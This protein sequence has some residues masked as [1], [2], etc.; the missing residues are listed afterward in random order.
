MKQLFL[1]ILGAG[2]VLLAAAQTE[3][4]LYMGTYTGTG[5]HG[6]Y[7]AKVNTA[8]GIIRLVD[9]LAAD[10]PSYLALNKAGNRLYAVTENGGSNPGAATSFMREEGTGKWMP[11]NASPQLTGGDHPCYIAVNKAGTHAVVANYTGGSVSVFAID[12]AGALGAASQLIQHRGSSVNKGRQEKPHVHST[13]FSP[14]EQYLMVADLGTDY[15]TAY[16]FHANNASAPL[17]TVKALRLKLSA[18]AGPRH[19]SFHPTLP[20]VYVMEELSG[21][22]AV[23][24]F[25]PRQRQLQVL[26]TIQSDRVSKQPGS[27][28]IHLS[29]DGKF[30]YASN[31]IEANDLAVFAVDAGTGQL[32][33]VQSI[34]TGGIKPRNFTLSPDG[35][36]VLVANQESNNIVLF[37]RHAGTGLLTPANVTLSLPSPVCLVFGQ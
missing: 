7:V 12:H 27:A 30:L 8:T 23:V 9:S 26:Q 14:N 25:A 34:R 20:I 21:K 19:V 3:W 5:S 22:V 29:P 13:I 24:R 31:R 6:I 1:S 18:G 33:F 36:F 10:N 17:D 2:T 4:T 35:R 32:R 28:D 16:P 37:H 11:L 15:I